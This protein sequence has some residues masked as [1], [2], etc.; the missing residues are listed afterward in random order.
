LD[1]YE[2]Y[3]E[4]LEKTQAIRQ[5]HPENSKVEQETINTRDHIYDNLEKPKG[6]LE[7]LDTLEARNV[8]MSHEENRRA[9]LRTRQAEIERL[10]GRPAKLR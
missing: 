3:L 2:Q 9:H 10:L 8:G 4:L 1:Q 7:K 6:V 5:R